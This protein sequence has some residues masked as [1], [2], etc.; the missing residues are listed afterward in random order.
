MSDTILKDV[1]INARQESYRMRHFHLGV[2]HLFIAL[3]DL[4][5]GLANQFFNSRNFTASY[6]TD[7]IRRKLGKGGRHRLWAG[8]P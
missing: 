5:D 2:E 1:L 4:Q 6:L 8:I 3:L 7:I